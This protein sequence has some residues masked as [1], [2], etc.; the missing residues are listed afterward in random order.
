MSIVRLTRSKVAH[1]SERNPPLAMHGLEDE[2]SAP[3]KTAIS[4]A[5][6]TIASYVPSEIIA[7]Y[8]LVIGMVVSDQGAPAGEPAA[9][10]HLPLWAFVTFAA[11]IPFVVWLLY[12][13]QKVERKEPVPWSPQTWPYWEAIS[14]IV[15][16]TAWSAA[17]PKSAFLKWEWFSA[18]I[19]AIGLVV[20]SIVI[21]LVG[22]LWTR[23]S[24]T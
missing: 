18:P 17:L 5:L 16:F 9:P 2:P 13:V 6:S 7:V 1:E 19:A 24:R 8:T 14:S 15:A 22:V 12:A 4:D 21:P 3:E 20:L 23:R 10:P 11:A